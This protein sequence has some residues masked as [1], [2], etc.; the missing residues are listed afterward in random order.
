MAKSTGRPTEKQYVE[1]PLLAQLE[2]LGW[3]VIDINDT[4]VNYPENSLRKSFSEVIIGKE[5]AAALMR[6]NPWLAGYQIPELISQLQAYPTL[7]PLENNADLF[8]R[9]DGFNNFTCVDESTGENRPVC[10]IDFNDI[11]NFN[12]ESSKNHFLAVSQYKIRI[13]G[14]EE[15]IIPDIVL[16]VNGL[17]L[18]VIEC[19]APDIEDPVAMGIEQLLRYQNRRDSRDMEGVPE[20]FYYNQFMVSTCYHEARY[21]TITGRENH[22][23]EWKDPYPRKLSDI[24]TKGTVSSQELLAA[25]MLDPSHLLDIIQN[26]TVFIEDDEGNTIKVVARYMQYRGAS[27]IIERLRSSGDSSKK[28]GTIWH[29]QGSG[30]SLTMMFVVRKMYHSKDLHDYKIVLLIDRKDLQTQILETSKAIRYK[31]NLAGSIQHLKNLIQNTS[32]DVSIAM[33]HKFGEYENKKEKFPVLNT[34]PKILVMIDEAHR[35]EYSELAANMWRSMPNSIKVAFTGTPIAKTTENFGG[36]I[37]SYTMRQAVDDGVIVEI[38]YEGRA[39]RSEITDADAMNNKFLD[40]FRYCS[41]EEKQQIM[42]RFTWQGYLE[43]NDVIHAKA[44]NMLDHYISTVFSNGFKAQVAAVS[45]EAA[46]R[47]KAAM[48]ELLPQKIEALKKDN[49]HNVDITRL[50]KLRIACVISTRQNDELYLK[51]L[52]DETVNKNIVAGFKLPFSEQNTS[53]F[54]SNYGI[55]IVASMLLTGFDAPVEQVLYLD[56]YITNHNLLQAIARVNRTSGPNKKCGYVVDYV[57]ITRHLK[58]ALGDYANGAIE[59]TLSVLKTDGDDIDALNNA[60]NIIRQFLLE[61]LHIESLDDNEDIIEKLTADDEMRELFNAYFRDFS[62]YF[63]RVLPNPAALEY[64]TDY[65]QLA[66]IRQSVANR[67]RDPR[68]SMRDA[69]KKV[70]AIIEEYLS[71]HGIDIKIPPIS[72]LS[73]DFLKNVKGKTDRAVSDEITYSVREYINKNNAKDPDYFERLSDK[74]N[75]ILEEYAENWAALRNELEKMWQED[76]I[77]GRKREKTFGFDPETEMP[78]FAILKK[79]IFGTKDYTELTE[80]EFNILK[81]L[82]TDILE[83]IKTDTKLVNFWNNQ[84]MIDQTRNHIITQLIKPSI[85]AIKSDIV[86]KRTEIAQKIMELGYQH[87][88][89]GV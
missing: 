41:G 83:R 6:L 45:R 23:I 80:Q 33:V 20:L 55:I 18:V 59:E 64:S 50:E 56:K 47:Y 11:D 61:K 12:K 29:T 81:D 30:K 77:E 26:Y 15:H 88:K 57:G 69:S 71:V 49:P 86:S 28:G 22:Y 65:K 75:K 54:D 10:L 46:Y 87:Y 24:K 19:K 89:G 31:P 74:L 2:D 82:T 48:E 14:K 37:D 8:D 9:I 25:G 34:S 60:Y 53:G 62:K 39:D 84:T 40:V 67:C 32:S 4:E 70:R 63:D 68:F 73:P 16:F 17:P 21:S 52:G 43:D 7:K 78:F 72:V 38:K 85:K 5:L 27:K 76:I 13:P 51:A 58:E 3:D 1:Q 36:I 44:S 35:S 42:G 79:D 66:F